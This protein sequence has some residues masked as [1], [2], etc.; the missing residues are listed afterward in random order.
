M[1]WRNN[2]QTFYAKYCNYLRNEM[3]KWIWRHD[4]PI[5]KQR[6]HDREKKRTREREREKE[7]RKRGN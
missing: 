2:E 6:G 4:M 1:T 5:D 7:K 3:G